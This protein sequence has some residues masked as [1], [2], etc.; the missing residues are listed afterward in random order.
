MVPCT[1]QCKELVIYNNT[2]TIHG[3]ICLKHVVIMCMKHRGM[4][5]IGERRNIRRETFLSA[6]LSTV[7]PTWD[8]TWTCAVRNRRMAVWYLCAYDLIPKFFVSHFPID[9]VSILLCSSFLHGT[10]TSETQVNIF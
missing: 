8:H 5:V 9:L 7:N 4:T 2:H 3:Y 1:E 6:N 10:P